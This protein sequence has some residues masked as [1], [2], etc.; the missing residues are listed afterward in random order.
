MLA[1]EA[2]HHLLLL[3]GIEADLLHIA[4][5]LSK[6]VVH[7]RAERI[8]SSSRLSVWL[9]KPRINEPFENHARSLWRPLNHA[10]DI[11]TIARAISPTATTSGT[12]R[13]GPEAVK[14]RCGGRDADH[15]A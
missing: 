3:E 13:W 11:G 2:L 9:H 14:R 5:I 6:L 12:S 15:P 7:G 4:R 1:N 8:R 10:S